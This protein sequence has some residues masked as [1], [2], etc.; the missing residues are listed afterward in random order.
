LQRREGDPLYLE[1][2][3]ALDTSRLRD[4][5]VSDSGFVFDPTTGHTY[6][7]N[8]TALA[9]LRALKDGAAPDEVARALDAAFELDGSEDLERDVQEFLS[10][11][12]AQGLVK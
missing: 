10:Q 12:R 7:L 9:V 11:L 8:A 4:L 2:G 1:T 5:A 6:T 3:M